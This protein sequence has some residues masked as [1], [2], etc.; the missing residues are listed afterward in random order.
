MEEKAQKEKDD[1][2]D[3]IEIILKGLR[4]CRIAQYKSYWMV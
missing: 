4:E 2:Y 3:G 1:F